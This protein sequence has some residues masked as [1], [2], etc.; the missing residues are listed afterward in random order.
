MRTLRSKSIVDLKTA[1]ENG[2]LLEGLAF[3]G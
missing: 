3:A 1:I 2:K